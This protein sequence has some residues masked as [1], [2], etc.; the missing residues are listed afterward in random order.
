MLIFVATETMLFAG[1]ISAF[2]VYRASSVVW[3]PP[4][5]PRL[6]FEETAVNTIALLASGVL[7]YL[8]CR[9]LRAGD[10]TKGHKFLLASTALGAFFVFF[11]G[12]EW[13]ALISDGLTLTSSNLGGFFFLIIGLHALHAIAAV[14]VLFHAWLSLRKGFVSLSLLAAAE[15]F[16]YFVVGVWPVIYL[17]VYL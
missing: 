11:Q 10:H 8:A 17:R 5:Q 2:T 6:P 9:T 4:D 1:L 3:P 14:G 13:V 15:V 16:W 7:L 12:A